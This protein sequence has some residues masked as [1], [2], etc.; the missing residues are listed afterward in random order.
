MI[1]RTVPDVV[2]AFGGSAEVAKWAG[3]GQSAISNWIA[4]GFIPP[5]WHYRMSKW[6]AERGYEI[7]PAVFG[8]DDKEQKRNGDRKKSEQVRS[9][10]A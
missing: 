9:Q 10:V 6:A 5:G 7:S 3:H 1:L 4:R 2:R 8:E